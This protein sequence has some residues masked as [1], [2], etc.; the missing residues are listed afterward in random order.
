MDETPPD[1]WQALAAQGDDWLAYGAGEAE[2]VEAP[3]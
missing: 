1:S 2:L 3:D